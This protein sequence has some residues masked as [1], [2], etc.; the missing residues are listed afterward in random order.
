M[1]ECTTLFA[2]FFDN[3]DFEVDTSNNTFHCPISVKA[4][5]VFRVS[6]LDSTGIP[7]K[8][9]WTLS[10]A[11]EIDDSMILSTSLTSMERM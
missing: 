2:G 6:L 7:R 3:V 10:S 8:S 11:I 4:S 5:K 9:Y 1:H